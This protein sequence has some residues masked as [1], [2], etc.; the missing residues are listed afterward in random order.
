MGVTLCSPQTPHGAAALDGVG[1]GRGLV[2]A[3]SGELEVCW[4]G[5][6]IRLGI[7]V[8]IGVEKGLGIG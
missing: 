5:V 3:K 4:F 8:K 1:A 6:K 2:S 7:G